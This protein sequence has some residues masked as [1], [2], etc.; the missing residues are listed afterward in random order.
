MLNPRLLPALALALACF[1]LSGCGDQAKSV[2]G[3]PT[4]APLSATPMAGA[5][6]Q[7]GPTQSAAAWTRPEAMARAAAAYN[8]CIARV[9]GNADESLQK[10][11]LLHCRDAHTEASKNA[12][13]MRESVPVET[14]TSCLMTAARAP[15]VEL[16]E[17]M[18]R[19]CHAKFPN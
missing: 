16:H 14:L 9:N 18:A 10:A 17:Q 7:A 11:W 6:T 19:D 4:D 12:A 8:A 15:Y 3:G 5:A 2:S 1:V 13:N